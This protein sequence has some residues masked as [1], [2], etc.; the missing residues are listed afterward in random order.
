MLQPGDMIVATWGCREY[1]SAGDKA[2]L[3]ILDK[4]G[5]WW[6]DFK[7]QGN[8]RVNG[9]GIWCVG[10]NGAQWTFEEIIVTHT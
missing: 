5:Y 7:D 4:D 10:K 1:Y 9:D 2:K 3:V 6:A 8:A